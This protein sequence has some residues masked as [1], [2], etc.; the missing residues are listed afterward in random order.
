MEEDV[1]AQIQPQEIPIDTTVINDEYEAKKQLII[2][3]TYL[4]SNRLTQLRR[5]LRQT[6]REMLEI[7]AIETQLDKLNKE[8]D[9]LKKK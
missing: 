7:K 4:L 6:D 1:E 9:S 8:L 3:E 5:K 2:E